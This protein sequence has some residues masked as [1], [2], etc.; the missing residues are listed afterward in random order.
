MAE[1][2][3]A[4]KGTQKSAKST[5]TINKKSNGF[6]DEER[7]AMKERAQE[8]KAAARRRPGADK[9]DGER[10]VLEK[11]AEM[12]E[13]DRD[14]ASGSMR[15]SKPA[16]RSSRRNSGT[17]CPRMPRTARSSASPKRAEVQD[18]VRNVGL[19]RQGE[20]R[21]RRHVA[22]RF[23]S[24]GVDRRRRG[25]DHRAREESGE[26]KTELATGPRPKRDR[27]SG[28]GVRASK[29]SCAD[30]SDVG[31]AP[32]RGAPH[33]HHLGHGHQA[34]PVSP[35]SDA[36]SGREPPALARTVIE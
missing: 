33:R 14:T 29:Y 35:R 3:S 24:T 21:R 5:T 25:K 20:P 23:R 32:D 16:R 27:R 9:A 19:Q 10:A 22:N 12:S 26:L 28:R 36:P 11:I 30:E 4:K 13:P 17:G 1:R 7:V 6:T 34:R 2:Q 15:S 8:L 18:E 31:N